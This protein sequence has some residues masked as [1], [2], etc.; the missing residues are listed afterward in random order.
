MHIIA[1]VFFLKE[2]VSTAL[3]SS[4]TRDTVRYSINKCGDP[5]RIQPLKSTL[6]FDRMASGSTVLSSEAPRII[7]GSPLRPSRQTP[8]LYVEGPHLFKLFGD[9]VV[10]FGY[11]EDGR[12]DSGLPVFSTGQEQPQGVDLEEDWGWSE[13]GGMGVFG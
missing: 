8:R 10:I 13:L 5:V 12:S 7:L 3:P 6:D 9:L 1:I 4:R 11:S 2:T